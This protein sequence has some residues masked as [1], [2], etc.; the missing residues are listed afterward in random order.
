MRRVIVDA[1]TA[2]DARRICR[3][4]CGW[5]PDAVREVDGGY[6]DEYDRGDR[7]R[8]RA[9]MCFESA[10]DAEIWDKQV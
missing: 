9:W 7:L 4:E 3:G 8:N 1:K 5:T 10:A 6:G 2:D